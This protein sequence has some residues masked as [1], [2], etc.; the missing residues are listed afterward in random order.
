MGRT[1]TGCDVSYQERQGQWWT[2]GGY[3]KISGYFCPDCYDMI[4]HDSDR[5]PKNPAAYTMMLL[6]LGAK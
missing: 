1:C 5:K 2:C 6:K 4:A 3:F